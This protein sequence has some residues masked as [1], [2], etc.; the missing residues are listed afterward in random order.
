MRKFVVLLTF[1][2]KIC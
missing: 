1:I 2:Y